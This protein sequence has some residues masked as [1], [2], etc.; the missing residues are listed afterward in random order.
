MLFMYV[1]NAN[2]SHSVLRST[3]K[4]L[5]FILVKTNCPRTAADRSSISHAS[6]SRLVHVHH[7]ARLNDASIKC[8]PVSILPQS[9]CPSYLSHGVR[10]TLI[11]ERLLG[12]YIE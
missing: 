1:M 11:D 2:C 3:K 10:W 7:I 5:I 6:F 4:C 12:F 8:C 9:R